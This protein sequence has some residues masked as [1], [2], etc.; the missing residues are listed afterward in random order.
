MSGSHPIRSPNHIPA[1]GL[2]ASTSQSRAQGV[3]MLA[4]ASASGG[5]TV[6]AVQNV[7]TATLQ[8]PQ[9]Q[10]RTEAPNLQVRLAAW[11]APR[12]SLPRDVLVTHLMPFLEPG[13]AE[14]SWASAANGARRNS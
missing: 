12:L 8:Q 5:V 9:P 11:E 13:A 4:S 10:T 7:A 14:L 2:E 1:A 3:S 6:A